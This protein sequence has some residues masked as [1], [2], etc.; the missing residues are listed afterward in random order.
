MALEVAQQGCDN[1][2][3]RDSI[4]FNSNIFTETLK[5]QDPAIVTWS[6]SDRNLTRYG[7]YELIALKEH[8][9]ESNR[10]PQCFYDPTLM[11]LNIFK[12]NVQHPELFEQ[13]MNSFREKLQN[14]TLQSWDPNVLHMLN[15]YHNAI[16]NP[17]MLQGMSLKL[18]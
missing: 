4:K 10:P 13:Q 17:N 2:E 12:Y 1:R 14:L 15:N 18:N 6:G 11:R 5:S 7:K 8:M 3:F 16:L 9:N